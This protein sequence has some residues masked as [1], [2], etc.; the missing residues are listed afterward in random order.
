MFAVI[1]L[2][3][4][5]IIDVWGFSNLREAKEYFDSKVNIGSRQRNADERFYGDQIMLTK[6][7]GVQ[8]M[9]HLWHDNFLGK[10][11]RLVKEH[12]LF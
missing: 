7:L 3:N 10:N 9:N 8:E 2:L 5:R 4:E 1:T 6:S 11:H 12:F